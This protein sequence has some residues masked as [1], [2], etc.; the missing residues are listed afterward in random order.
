VIYSIPVHQYCSVKANW[1]VRGGVL[2]VLL[3]HSLS[4]SRSDSFK[5]QRTAPGTYFIGG[6]IC[7]RAGRDGTQKSFWHTGNKTTIVLVQS[8]SLVSAAQTHDCLIYGK[9]VCLC[10]FVYL[11]V[12]GCRTHL[13]AAFSSCF[14]NS[15]Y[16]VLT[17]FGI[18]RYLALGHTVLG[19]GSLAEHFE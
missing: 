3:Q 19:N 11:C 9:R 16:S 4:R 14:H 5:A 13:L 17:V 7:S 2:H 1:K 18:L 10:L 8:Q 12:F 6:W 15:F